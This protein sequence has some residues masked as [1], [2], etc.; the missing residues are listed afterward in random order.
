MDYKV[1]NLDLPMKALRASIDGY[2]TILQSSFCPNRRWKKITG[3]LLTQHNEI[4]TLG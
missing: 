2:R 1:D 3:C 4:Q